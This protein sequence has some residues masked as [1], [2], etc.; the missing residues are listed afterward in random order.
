MI[1][2]CRL[3]HSELEIDS[4][5]VSELMTIRSARFIKTRKAPALSTNHKE[6]SEGRR[7]SLPQEREYDDAVEPSSVRRRPRLIYVSASAWIGH[8]LKSPAPERRQAAEENNH[9]IGL[10]N[11]LSRTA[12]PHP[13]RLNLRHSLRTS[14]RYFFSSE[15]NPIFESVRTSPEFWI[16]WSFCSTIDNCCWRSWTRI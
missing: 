11:R 12:V 2:H 8:A 9:L 6:R 3:R 14:R 15:N 1:Y 4:W 13:E 5:R 7:V 10:E 16:C